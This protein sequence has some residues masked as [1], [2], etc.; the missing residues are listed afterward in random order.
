MSQALTLLEFLRQI[1]KA[2]LH[3][4]LLG[5]VRPETMLDFAKKYH[6]PLSEEEAHSY[7][8]AY[9]A[10]NMPRKGGILALKLLYQLMQRPEDYYRVVLEVAED[11]ARV[12]LRYIETF[13]NPSDTAL[14]YATLNQTL[15]AAADAA[16]AQFNV[17]IRFIPSINREKSPEIALAMVQE[18]IAH[19]H[20]YVLG[21]GIDYKEQNAGVEQFWLAYRQAR[22]QGLKLTAHCSEFGL[23]WRNVQAGIELNGCDRI[24]HGYTIVDNPELCE[25]YARAGIPF[26]VVPS[27]T[28]YLKEWPQLSQWQ[29][30]HP[31]RKM[32]R[33]GLTIIPCTDDWHIHNTN[34]AECYRVMIEQLGFD[35]DA[36]RQMMINSL[37]AAWISSTQRQEWKQQWLNTFDDLRKKLAHEPTIPDALYTP[38]HRKFSGV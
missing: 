5:G 1:P 12:G 13:W 17:I 30:N 26:T 11:A 34:S 36:I 28:Y 21:I 3:Y 32:A 25:K 37:D 18:V 7:Y 38:Y 35:L 14:N 23:H 20:P 29:A 16:A 19:P 9:Q 6:V 8:R 4:H 27:N 22:Q 15:I 2:D 10:P 33:A 24:D 31:I